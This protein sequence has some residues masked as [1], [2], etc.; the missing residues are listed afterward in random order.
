MSKDIVKSLVTKKFSEAKDL[1]F[2]ALYAKAALAMD[3]ARLGVASSVFNTPLDE[4]ES[5][6]NEAKGDKKKYNYVGKD[7]NIVKSSKAP[8]F[9]NFKRGGGTLMHPRHAAK[10]KSVK[11]E[12]DMKELDAERQLKARKAHVDKFYA[13]KAKEKA[14]RSPSEIEKDAKTDAYRAAY[15]KKTGKRLGRID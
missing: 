2:Q 9:V 4:E 15:T 5:E 14:S 11:E 8:V 3:D 7:G 10:K 1:V 6:C 13:R 12:S